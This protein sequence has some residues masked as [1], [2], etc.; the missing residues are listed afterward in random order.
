MLHKEFLPEAMQ[1]LIDGGP[2]VAKHAALQEW[3]DVI[4][5]I[6][7]LSDAMRKELQKETPRILL[8]D[9]TLVTKAAAT[10]RHYLKHFPKV[11]ESRRPAAETVNDIA[12]EARDGAHAILQLPS[13]QSARRA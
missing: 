5:A 10:M 11:L 9:V 1:Q 3:D 12:C 8:E 6:F 2:A 4:V 7:A 13:K